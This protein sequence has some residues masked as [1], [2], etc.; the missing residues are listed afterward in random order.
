M[1]LWLSESWRSFLHSS[2]VY[3][4]HLCIISS[5]S[6]RFIPFLSFI[7]PIFAWNIPL[8]S[9]I[10]LKRSLVF[11]I[12][13]FLSI[14]LH[15]SLRKA[16]LSLLAI[17]WN[18]A[19]RRIYLSFSPLTFKGHEAKTI[20]QGLEEDTFI[21]PQTQKM[22]VLLSGFGWPEVSREAS[23]TELRA[24]GDPANCPRRPQ[25]VSKTRVYVTY[26]FIL[27]FPNQQSNT[28][29]VALACSFLR[30]EL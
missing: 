8:V 22:F 21:I 3:S 1:P 25:L 18:S 19:F 15:W 26:C 27:L 12:L 2:F 4:C 9:L 24:L 30:W 6:L 10:F 7:V 29:W 23:C 11:P 16:F 17:L 13:L 20:L 14:S 5:A 28:W